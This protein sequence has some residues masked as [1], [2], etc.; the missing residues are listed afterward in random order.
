MLMHQEWNTADEQQKEKKKTYNANEMNFARVRNSLS[1]GTVAYVVLLVFPS[2][3][4]RTSTVYIFAHGLQL[5]VGS[6]VF[7]AVSLATFIFLRFDSKSVY[8]S[9]AN[10]WC[11]Y[12]ARAH[13]HTH[14]LHCHLNGPL[15]WAIS[16]I[17]K[18]QYAIQRLSSSRWRK[19]NWNYINI[20]AQSPIL[21]N[22]IRKP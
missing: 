22:T 17:N 1:R 8:W 4:C 3:V 20:I 12:C 13:T 15:L 9:E 18:Y 10:T 14:I 5:F 21:L 6:W 19:T 11:F 7:F 16:S 2:T